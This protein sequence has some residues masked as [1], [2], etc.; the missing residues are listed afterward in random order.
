[1][2]ANHDELGCPRRWGELGVANG[3]ALHGPCEGG[4]DLPHWGY[5]IRGAMRVSYPD[6]D[7]VIST[8]DAYYVAPGHVAIE[9]RDAEVVGFTPAADPS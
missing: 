8:G 7:E 4:C 9:L 5:V 1:V 2:R 6:H 3:Q